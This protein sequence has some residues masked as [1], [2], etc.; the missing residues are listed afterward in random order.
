MKG[1]KGGRRNVSPWATWRNV[2]QEPSYEENAYEGLYEDSGYGVDTSS[3]PPPAMNGWEGYYE[4][5]YPPQPQ[6]TPTQEG[7][8]PPTEHYHSQAPLM[9]SSTAGYSEYVPPQSVPSSPPLPPTFTDSPQQTYGQRGDSCRA[10]KF[11]IQ[12]READI[13]RHVS[14]WATW[15]PK[16]DNQSVV[17]C[18]A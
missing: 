8:Y 9:Y 12:P 11:H 6:Y 13:R 17:K 2:P 5:G 14:P 15:L 7:L 10:Q 18:S 1:G 16:D 3:V 4:N